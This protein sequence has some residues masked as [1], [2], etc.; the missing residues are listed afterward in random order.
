MTIKPNQCK[1]SREILRL[2]RLSSLEKTSAKHHPSKGLQQLPGWWLSAW[3]LTSTSKDLGC[4]L[5][6]QGRA[7]K[8][9]ECIGNEENQQR[10]LGNIGRTEQRGCGGRCCWANWVSHLHQHTQPQWPT[11]GK[12]WGKKPQLCILKTQSGVYMSSSHLLSS[13]ILTKYSN[14]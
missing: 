7:I 14:V 12:I 6:V 11:T 9:E 5:W 10:I 8:G 2:K 1:L 3:R 4:R 13:R